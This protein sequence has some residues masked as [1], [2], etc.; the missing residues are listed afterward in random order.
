MTDIILCQY[1]VSSK[2]TKQEAEGWI[3]KEVVEMK[4]VGQSSINPEDSHKLFSSAPT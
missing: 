2:E 1:A 3:K 4:F